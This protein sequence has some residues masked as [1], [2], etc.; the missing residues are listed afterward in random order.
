MWPFL[1]LLALVPI[2]RRAGTD[3]SL[4]TLENFTT[5]FTPEEIHIPVEEALQNAQEAGYFK[6]PCAVGCS[7]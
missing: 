4:S 5:G 7:H 2:W 6:R 1:F 3:R